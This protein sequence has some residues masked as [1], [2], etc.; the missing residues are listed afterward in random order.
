MNL[1]PV[2]C[3]QSGNGKSRYLSE[4]E[5]DLLAL[6][7]GCDEQGRDELAGVGCEG[8]H[9]EGH[10]ERRD[11]GLPREDGDRINLENRCELFS[12]ESANLFSVERTQG[13]GRDARLG[14]E[15]QIN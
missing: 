12:S 11:L 10:K 8:R 6:L 9:D 15:G 14:E 13:R 7:L 5:R 2:E 1:L 4:C 3:R